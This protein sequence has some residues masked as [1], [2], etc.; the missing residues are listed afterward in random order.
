MEKIMR[1]YE[2]IISA[3]LALP[4]SARAMLAEHL[5][6]S[7]D[8]EDQERIDALW[9]EEA[10]RR[11]NEIEDGIIAAIAGEEVMNRLRSR[12]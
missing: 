7:L 6:E 11:D 3:A 8:A 10:E 12:Y 1:T 4:P 2:E 9:A 5:M